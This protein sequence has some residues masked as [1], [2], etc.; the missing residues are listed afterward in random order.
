MIVYGRGSYLTDEPGWQRSMFGWARHDS[1]SSLAFNTLARTRPV[2]HSLAVGS[3]I[4]C[5][6]SL[7][8]GPRSPASWAA[9]LLIGNL[10]FGPL[11]TKFAQRKSIA[12]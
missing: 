11:F 5:V 1:P 9:G 3:A 8:F 4:G 10:V 6:L 7:S 12:S 2:W